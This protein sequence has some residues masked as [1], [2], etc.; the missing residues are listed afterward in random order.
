MPSVPI[1]DAWGGVLPQPGQGHSALHT[2][3]GPCE[4]APPL[5]SKRGTDACRCQALGAP[6]GS[7]FYCVPPPTSSP[8]CLT[9]SA[10]LRGTG[11]SSSG[12]QM[13][14]QVWPQWAPQKPLVLHSFPR[15]PR[16]AGVGQSQGPGGLGAISLQVSSALSPCGLCRAQP[17]TSLSRCLLRPKAKSGPLRRTLR[18][19]CAQQCHLLP[20][21]GR[22]GVATAL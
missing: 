4:G 22:S 10:G 16:R 13:E 9:R 8:I 1:T 18:S 5:P 15:G 2:R 3:E 7:L 20:L 21:S 11:P 19:E 14:V 17:V 12:H 6:L